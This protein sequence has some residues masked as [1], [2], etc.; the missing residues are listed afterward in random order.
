MTRGFSA[1]YSD[2]LLMDLRKSSGTVTLFGT[3]RSRC[4]GVL[5]EREPPP[6]DPPVTDRPPP[7]T[8]TDPNPP[9]PSDPPQEDQRPIS[10]PPWPSREPS[11]PP[12]AARLKPGRD[13]SVM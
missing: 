8:P 11:V 12:P 6:A 2:V 9:Q 4:H 1:L 7:P 13:V 5:G 10:D 3:P